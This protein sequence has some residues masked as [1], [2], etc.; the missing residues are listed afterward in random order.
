MTGYLQSRAEW[1]DDICQQRSELGEHVLNV[2][3]HVPAQ[4]QVRRASVRQAPVLQRALG[5]TEQLGEFLLGEEW[6]C[7]VASIPRRCTSEAVSS[8]PV[9]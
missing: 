1:L 5:Q 2:V 7:V 9:S 3:P 4:R 8:P 6:I